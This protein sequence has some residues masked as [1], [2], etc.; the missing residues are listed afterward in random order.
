[1]SSSLKDSGIVSFV[2]EGTS[3]A[4]ITQRISQPKQNVH[5]DVIDLDEDT[6]ASCNTSATHLVSEI[7]F[8][9]KFSSFVFD[10]Q[11]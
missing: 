8:E 4:V 5:T 1:M 10:V 7:Y 2:Q 9:L 11:V 6:E 3:G